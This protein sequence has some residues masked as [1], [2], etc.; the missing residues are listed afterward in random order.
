M[1][2]QRLEIEAAAPTQGQWRARWL[3]LV[4]IAAFAWLFVQAFNYSG[5][6]AWAAEW[7]FAHFARYFPVL[8]ILLFLG[9]MGAVWMLVSGLWRRLRGRPGGLSGLALQLHRSARLRNFLYFLTA[10]SAFMALGTFIQ[11][12][13]QP[14]MRGPATVTAM[15]PGAVVPLKA[16]P[17]ELRDFHVIGPVARYSQD[18]LF[19]R[20]T[21]YL[22][23]V[24]QISRPGR[25]PALN[26]FV[27]MLGPDVRT[28]MPQP[29][30]GLLRI[31]SLMPEVRALYNQSRI[32]TA[33]RSAIL[34]LSESSA[35]RP[36]M[37]LMAEFIIFG[38]LMFLFA[39]LLARRERRFIK[40]L[41]PD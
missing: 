3:P 24:G 19:L 32:P 8:T 31:N 5:L 4:T 25:A 39:R 11:Y 6:V 14:G 29:V 30:S 9:L 13:Q 15:R 22:A 36:Y 33:R 17:V 18:F 38:L 40:T 1:T 23:P 37:V 12:M 27:E 35:N 21:R 41:R 16:G 26:L 7:Q 34:F 20:R 2:G 28:D 10:V